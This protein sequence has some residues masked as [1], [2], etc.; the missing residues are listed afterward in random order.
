[1]QIAKFDNTFYPLEKQAQAL[2]NKV[3]NIQKCSKTRGNDQSKMTYEQA[4]VYESEITKIP[5]TTVEFTQFLD[6]LNQ[7][8]EPIE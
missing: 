2:F 3:H 1:M 6:V 5:V 7:A 4:L 8:K